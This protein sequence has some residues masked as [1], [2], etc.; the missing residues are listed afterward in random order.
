MFYITS[1]I[2]VVSA[3]VGFI[4]YLVL[5]ITIFKGKTLMSETWFNAGYMIG[6]Q[7]MQIWIYFK[8]LIGLVQ[9]YSMYELSCFLIAQ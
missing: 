5:D 6:D 9:F 7:S 8:L 3:W 1:L 4:D 2:C